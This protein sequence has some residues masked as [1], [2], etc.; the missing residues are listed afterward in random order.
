LFPRAEKRNVN[1][2]FWTREKSKGFR[3]QAREIQNKVLL[4]LLTGAGFRKRKHPLLKS[5]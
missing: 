4:R 2:T 3:N 5:V 1:T